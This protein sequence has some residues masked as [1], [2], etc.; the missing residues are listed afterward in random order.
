MKFIL[1]ENWII[2]RHLF[3]VSTKQWT[4][5]E[6]SAEQ[7]NC[8][9]YLQITMIL[10]CEWNK[11]ATCFASMSTMRVCSN[12]WVYMLDLLFVSKLHCKKVLCNS[13]SVQPPANLIVFC[14]SKTATI[15]I[16]VRNLTN[17]SM[18]YIAMA[19][20]FLLIVC[21]LRY[22]DFQEGGGLLFYYLSC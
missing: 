15:K 12:E 22:G 6:Q 4:S 5:V 17:Y 16:P 19:Y 10:V 11:I 14:K 13:K 21:S 3:L 7:Q 8:I 1:V 20:D 2:I 18:P 9:C